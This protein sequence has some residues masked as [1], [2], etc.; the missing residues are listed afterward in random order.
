MEPESTWVHAKFTN[1]SANVNGNAIAC[2]F[3]NSAFA[4][5][6]KLESY[7]GYAQS[8]LAESHD[9][10]HILTNI[11][12]DLHFSAGEATSVWNMLA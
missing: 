6:S 11:L 7:H 4:L 10:T 8:T 9:N 3:D 12:Q 2:A 1:T 5:V